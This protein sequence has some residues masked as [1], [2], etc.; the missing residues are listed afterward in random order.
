MIFFFLSHQLNTASL[1]QNMMCPVT[2]SDERR[3]ALCII[4]LLF[5]RAVPVPSRGRGEGGRVLQLDAEAQVRVST[6]PDAEHQ[7][8][9]EQ[10][11]GSPARRR[12]RRQDPGGGEAGGGGLQQPRGCVA[13]PGPLRRVLGAQRRRQRRRA[14]ELL[15]RAGPRLHRPRLRELTEDQRH[16]PAGAQ[17]AA[18]G[19]LPEGAPPLPL[20]RRPRQPVQVA[21]VC[22]TVQ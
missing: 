17:G 4:L 3:F 9:Q 19:N 7:H 15:R 22:R 14:A 16:W 6:E 13:R 8:R 12:Q 1:V 5:G 18:A 21:A 11:A 10:R 2:L 20:P